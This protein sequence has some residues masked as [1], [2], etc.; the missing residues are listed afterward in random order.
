MRNMQRITNSLFI[1]ALAIFIPSQ[2]LAQVVAWGRNA[3]GQTTIPAGL[4]G[5]TAIAAGNGHTVA[6]K[7]DGTVVAWGFNGNGETTIPAGLSGVTAIAAGSHH[8]VALKRDGTVVAWGGNDYGQT[9][10]PAGLSGV[11]AIAAGGTHTVALKNDGTVVAWGNNGHGQTTIPAGLS[12]V[13]AI[14]AGGPHTVALKS[15]GTVVAW[16]YN[17]YGESTIPAGLSGV[18]AISAGDH[19]TVALKSDG[20]VVAWGWNAY[21]QTT[22]PAGLSGVTAIAAGFIHTV[23]LKN[24]GTVVAWGSNGNGQTTIPAGL[25]GVTAIAAGGYHTVALGGTIDTTPPVITPSVAGGIYTSAQ[26][27]TLSANETATIYYTLNGTT[28]TT[29]SAVYS[30][31]LSISATTTLKYFG[32]D[33]AGNSSAVQTQSYT[34][35][36]LAISTSSLAGGITG[37]A[38]SAAL[39]A[40][41]G[42]SP[43][44][45]SAPGLPAGL[46]INSST[47]AIS[48]T[49][50]TAG[51]YVFMATVTDAASAVFNK[52][53]SIVISDGTPVISDGT[54][55]TVPT[56]LTASAASAT[57][58][59]LAWT[60]STDN[61]GVTA[62]KVY[63]GGIL[64]ATL[65]N[66]TSYSDTGLTTA[67]AYSYTVAACDA[68]GNCSAQSA[69]V[70]LGTPALAAPVP[71]FSATASGTTSDLT[72]TASLS[73]GDAD[74]GRNGNVYL[75]AYT[76]SAWFVHNGSSWVSW[77]GGSLPAYAV[78]PLTNRSIEVVRNTNLSALVGTQV[79]VG[80][81]LSESDMLTNGKYGLVYTVTVTPVTLVSANVAG[82]HLG[83]CD[84]AGDFNLPAISAEGK[85][86]IFNCAAVNSVTG[87]LDST[88]TYRKDLQS[89]SIGSI[90]YVVT[91]ATGTLPTNQRDSI[92]SLGFPTTGYRLGQYFSMSAG[93][94]YV[95]FSTKS[96]SLVYIHIG[97]QTSGVA[98][99]RIDGG[100]N[101]DNEDLYVK[102]MVTGEIKLASSNAL[103]LASARTYNG[104]Y[105]IDF[106]SSSNIS[107]LNS[108]ISADGRYVAF[109]SDG[110]N[111]VLNDVN[112]STDMFVKDLVSGGIG[113]VNT[114]AAGVVQ[115]YFSGGY[116]PVVFSADGRYLVFVWGNSLMPLAANEAYA[117]S[118]GNIFRKDLQSNAIVRVGT[119]ANGALA[120]H[121]DGTVYTGTF[122][123]PAVSAD[124]R[125][126]VFK[127]S[128]ETLVSGDSNGVSDIFRKDLQTGEVKL[129][130]VTAA[131]VQGKS[132]STAFPNTISHYPSISADGRYVVFDNSGFDTSTT[133]N[134]SAACIKDMATGELK[135]MKTADGSGRLPKISADGKSVVIT[136]SAS[137]G[138]IYR[139]GNP[140]LGL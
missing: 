24:D 119:T 137:G 108:A 140:F 63:R 77:S 85:Y 61:V 44:T 88:E 11:T 120:R 10:I 62:Y 41:G 110:D 46:S 28:P 60:A 90:N 99:S 138:E 27:V 50:T 36:T 78:G 35:S 52:G 105:I 19:H 104:S 42:T 57:Q 34:I 116:T 8:T 73:I 111:L 117:T 93:G 94:Q 51:T 123:N 39:T 66:V 29:S 6:L 129:V 107:H 82:V 115:G 67:T 124:G 64:L 81:G 98:P 12:G 135:V 87:N 127:S 3:E 47:G 84:V 13:T 121:P 65:G 136:S 134:K 86:V 92:T 18:T 89:G 20:T 33:T 45:W 4:S 21:G 15:D 97:Q 17:G 59:N 122:D 72:L 91:D 40:S 139:I 71:T 76:G 30:T 9:T 37:T 14:A 7:N 58:I 74:V 68:A 130:S 31:P 126:V 22:I 56:G 113:R 95:L 48:G 79:Y 32:K 103:G 131:G 5:V 23:A 83:V 101:N 109:S 102:N 125:Y 1:L 26:S 43:Y 75:A 114:D 55:P 112:N 54:P 2:A 132:T 118:A 70:L 49:P 69:V 128:S 106:Y 25:S 80:Y 96:N 16:G 38:Y 133:A 100:D 53:F